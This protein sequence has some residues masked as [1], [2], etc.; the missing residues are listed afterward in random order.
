MQAPD[1]VRRSDVIYKGKYFLS[2][3]TTVQLF[4]KRRGCEIHTTVTKRD[5]ERHEPRTRC[6]LECCRQR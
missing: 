1:I 5:F 2:L 6:R 4:E 3:G